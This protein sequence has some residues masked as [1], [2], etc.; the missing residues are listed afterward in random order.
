LKSTPRR[1]EHEAGSK[2]SLQETN[3][4]QTVHKACL[5]HDAF[6]LDSLFN[7]EDGGN[8]FFRNVG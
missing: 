4:K 1:K 5:F 3:M 6:L 7:I 2:Q 8:M